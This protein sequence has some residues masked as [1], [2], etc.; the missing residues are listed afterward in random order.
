MGKNYPMVKP[1]K[2][3]DSV[4]CDSLIVIESRDKPIASKSSSVNQLDQ[5]EMANET[6]TATTNASSGTSSATISC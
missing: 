6:A 1:Y 2:V 4:I 5:H 3:G